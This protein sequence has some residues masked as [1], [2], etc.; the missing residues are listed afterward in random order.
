MSSVFDEGGDKDFAA[1]FFDFIDFCFAETFDFAEITFCGCL[2]CL[3]TLDKS[4]D[5]MG[6]GGDVDSANS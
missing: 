6:G 3:D 4:G 5:G 2:D 1:C